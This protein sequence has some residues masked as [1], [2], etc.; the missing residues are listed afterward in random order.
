MFSFYRTPLTS[1]FEVGRSV[2]GYRLRK[3]WVLGLGLVLGE[4]GS[5]SLPSAYIH[6]IGFH[7][8]FTISANTP[9]VTVDSS[10]VIKHKRKYS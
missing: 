1:L 8:F 9:Y 10:I 5:C 4:C 3:A 2:S 7:L 6:A